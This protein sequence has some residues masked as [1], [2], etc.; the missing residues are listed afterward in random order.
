MAAI[1]STSLHENTFVSLRGLEILD[2]RYS[3]TTTIEDGAFAG[4]DSLK[5][6]YLG[7]STISDPWKPS[8]KLFPLNAHEL[9][10][11]N[12]EVNGV[13][14]CWNLN[15]LI[16]LSLRKSTHF[17][18]NGNSFSHSNSLQYLD[19]TSSTLTDLPHEPFFCC[20]N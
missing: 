20:L 9:N 17:P 10:L 4:L 8:I 11:D 19:L 18:F 12:I 14:S 16:K 2:L 15:Q 6:L 13:Y 7:N 1:Q 3:V 5:T